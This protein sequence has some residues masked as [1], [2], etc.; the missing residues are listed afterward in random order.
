ME[1][2]K[3]KVTMKTRKKKQD[4]AEF[5]DVKRKAQAQKREEIE[6]L[7]KEEGYKP[8]GDVEMK[9]ASEVEGLQEEIDQ[10]END[11]ASY[12]VMDVA[13]DDEAEANADIPRTS[14]EPGDD[15]GGLL[16]VTDV[17]PA[18][19]T[20][21]GGVPVASVGRFG[22][23][24]Q[25]GAVTSKSR[26]AFGP[27]AH[28]GLPDACD[29]V[30]GTHRLCSKKESKGVYEGKKADFRN[31][32]GV[33]W[34]WEGK[35]HEEALDLLNP[36]I[37]KLSDQHTTLTQRKKYQKESM[38]KLKKFPIT[39]VLVSW[40]PEI[41]EDY[42]WESA[43]DFKRMWKDVIGAENMIYRAAVNQKVRYE[44]TDAGRAER[45]SSALYSRGNTPGTPEPSQG[46]Q[47]TTPEPPVTGQPKPP[48]VSGLPTPPRDTP[49][50]AEASED[51]KK[52]AFEGYLAEWY[53]ARGITKPN[54]VER[55]KARG[56]F[57]AVWE[58]EA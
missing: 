50:P 9:L 48:I 20:G 10:I 4:K 55:M 44:K 1:A 34:D 37:M 23:I 38:Q 43:S 8:D 32:H 33:S 19:T 24:L 40:K 21:V 3:S 53:K 22:A 51:V 49:E 31:L 6:K 30:K 12:E 57:D 58:S 27:G 25:Y 17:Q 39:Y 54:I 2:G 42:T 56:N 16:D 28:P 45:E 52:R 35:S 11:A 36:A 18:S 26:Y 41:R 5:Q 46:V 29:T 13:A 47:P 7:R 14:I 15:D